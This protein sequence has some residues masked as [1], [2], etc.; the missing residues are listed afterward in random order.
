MGGER[1]DRASLY[2]AIARM[3]LCVL[4]QCTLFMF[5]VGLRSDVGLQ[6]T[7]LYGLYLLKKF[8]EPYT[9]PLLHRHH[10]THQHHRE[11]IILLVLGVAALQNLDALHHSSLLVV[12]IPASGARFG[13]PSERRQTLRSELS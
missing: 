11:Q 2:S 5:L 9:P 10:R 1:G 4:V 7:V 13:P 8:K 3:R 6:T 12:F